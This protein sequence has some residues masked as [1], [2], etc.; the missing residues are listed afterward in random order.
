L[1]KEA[2]G[3]RE[4]S[5]VAAAEGAELRGD[6]PFAHGSQHTRMHMGMCGAHYRC[7]A[8]A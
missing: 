1:L 6:G 7:A 2:S 3:S 5:R 8:L 4:L